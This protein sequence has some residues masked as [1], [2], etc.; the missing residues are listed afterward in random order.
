MGCFLDLGEKTISY[1][2]NGQYFDIAFDIPNKL[3]GEVRTLSV[4]TLHTGHCEG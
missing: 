3:H 1:A 2:K 4:V